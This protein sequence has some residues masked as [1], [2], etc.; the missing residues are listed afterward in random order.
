MYGARR[1]GIYRMMSYSGPTP[2]AFPFEDAET[3]P[4]APFV[5]CVQI[6]GYSCPFPRLQ[7]PRYAV[8]EVVTANGSKEHYR[9]SL[10]TM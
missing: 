8:P 3:V 9:L 6:Y 4:A 10:A 5:P 1:G 2:C 7:H